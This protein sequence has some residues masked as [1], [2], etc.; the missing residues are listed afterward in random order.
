M[1][2]LWVLFLVAVIWVVS[3][4]DRVGCILAAVVIL[5]VGIGLAVA[6]PEWMVNG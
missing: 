1:T 2:T 3:T 5:L 4:G 6:G